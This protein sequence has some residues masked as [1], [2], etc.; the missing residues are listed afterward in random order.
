MEFA[1]KKSALGVSPGA[2]AD[3]ATPGDRPGSP[4]RCKPR[5]SIIFAATAVVVIAI[6]ALI[7]N[8]IIGRLAEDNLIR[9]TEENS[10]REG[11]H[12]QS[13][14]MTM[15][16]ELALEQVAQ[17]PSGLTGDQEGRTPNTVN[18][19]LQGGQ[20]TPETL[21]AAGVPEF[22]AN[23]F[24]E[25]QPSSEVLAEAGI[26]DSIA[27]LILGRPPT[28]EALSSAGVPDSIVNLL[29]AEQPSSQSLAS[30]ESAADSQPAVGSL[31][32]LASPL[33]LPVIYRDLTQKDSTSK[34]SACT[35]SMARRSGIQTLTPSTL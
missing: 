23:L 24:E 21:I 26:P 9:L 30:G 32:W 27:A 3:A 29:F 14:A 4:W 20:P 25:G 13:L 12:V 5:L 18:N 6:A 2:T 15:I 1:G 17:R 31:E 10:L 11:S 28:E 8:L 16:G 22:I 35:I 7:V 34:T 33:G 19:L